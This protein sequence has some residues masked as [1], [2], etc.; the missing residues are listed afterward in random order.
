MNKI[1]TICTHNGTFHCDEVMAIA[2]IKYLYNDI[3]IIRTRSSSVIQEHQHREDSMVIDVGKVYDHGKYCYDHHQVTFNEPLYPSRDDTDFIP[4]SSCGLI[5][6]HYGTEII[7]KIIK[8]NDISL[9]LLNSRFT[10]PDLEDIY[11]TFY[12]YFIKSID[13]GDNGINYTNNKVLYSPIIL[14]STI[15]KFNGINEELDFQKAV[16]YCSETFKIH[17]TSNIMKKLKYIEGL[18]VFQKCIDNTLPEL[19]ELGILVLDTYLPVHLYLKNIDP[20]QHYKFIIVNTSETVKLWTVKKKNKQF[21]IVKKLI[22]E[23]HARSL[24]GS[25]LIF[26]HK[27][28]FTGEVKSLNSAII[29][30][31]ESLNIP[32]KV[33]TSD[34]VFTPLN[35][36]PTIYSM[37]TIF[38]TVIILS[39]MIH[40]Q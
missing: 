25:D 23:E 29:I 38:A 3:T 28:C 37:T 10:I 20:N 19:K 34:E 22:N 26:I 4:L 6:R 9:E 2:M 13:A 36:S 33:F 7:R 24:V 32:D 8:D 39:V 11:D 30:I 1:K 14:P 16:D 18:P 12:T 40:N 17:L 5:Y 15:A 27:A 35:E 31:K 21:E